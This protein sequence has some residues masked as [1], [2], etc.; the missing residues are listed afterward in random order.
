MVGRYLAC[1]LS[2]RFR[3]QREKRNSISPRAH[4]LVS[5]CQPGCFVNCDYWFVKSSPGPKLNEYAPTNKTNALRVKYRSPLLANAGVG[6]VVLTED[7][8]TNEKDVELVENSE[9][10]VVEVT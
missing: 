9:E 10:L 4:A 1:E 7:R 5:T 3:V 2:E 8:E 6:L